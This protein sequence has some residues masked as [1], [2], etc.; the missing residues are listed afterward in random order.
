M[1]LMTSGGQRAC[2]QIRLVGDIIL[3]TV[4]E[5]TLFGG[6]FGDPHHTVSSV[7]GDS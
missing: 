7:L 5:R 2:G 6:F 1:F 4:Q 3:K